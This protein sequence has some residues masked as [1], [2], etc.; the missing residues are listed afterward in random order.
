[1]QCS[2]QGE[3]GESPVRARRREMPAKYRVC[4][5]V[6][7]ADQSLFYLDATIRGISLGKPE[8]MDKRKHQ[9]E[10]PNHR[11]PSTRIARA[12]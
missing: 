3:T 9:V 2:V 11:I 5:C 4:E 8:K 6:R 1:M 12:D 7:N 10:I